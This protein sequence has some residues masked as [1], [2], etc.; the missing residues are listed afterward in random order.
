MHAASNQN[1]EA[2]R[3]QRFPRKP[4]GH[5]RM[6]LPSLRKRMGALPRSSLKCEPVALATLGP[7]DVRIEGLAASLN[8]RD[9]AIALGLYAPH[10]TLPLTIG[11]DFCGIVVEVGS[12]V[13][14]FKPGD[15]I[16]THDIQDWLDGPGTRA[17]QRNTLGSPLQGVLATSCVLPE[18]GLVQTPKNLTAQEASTLP[19][20]ALTAWSALTATANVRSDDVVLVQGSGGVSLFAVQL[21]N[22]LGADVI[23]T[24]SSASKAERL[25]ALGASDVI[26]TPH[27]HDW[28]DQV[29]RKVS[30]GVDVVLDVGGGAT[31]TSSVRS[32]GHG[33]RVVCIGFL[34]GVEPKIP[35]QPLILNNASVVGVTVGSR[36]EFED[37]IAFIET[38]DV[39]PII[40]K[41]FSFDNVPNAFSRLAS[42]RQFGKVV[43]D[44]DPENSARKL[45][46]L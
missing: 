2:W 29:R 23:A 19:I 45:G 15:P 25:R 26:I 38:H 13:T 33:G 44:I 8:F 27:N 39:V 20:A 5:L 22:A 40:D 35:I 46:D 6:G 18:H 17:L 3:L 10:Q 16:V 12:D 21:A 37:L 30:G 24:T 34:G 42:G 32:L 43:I 31:V 4:F 7:Q 14:R 1:A 11:S 9:Y 28:S 36:S 41:V